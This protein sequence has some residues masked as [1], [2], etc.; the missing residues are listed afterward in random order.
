[1]MT[2][3]S[4]RPQWESDIY[5]IKRSDL[6]AGGRDGIANKQAQQL[7]NRTAFLKKSALK[8]G[9]TFRDGA[10]LETENDLIKYGDVLYAW[11][12]AFNKEVPAGSSP[13]ST[14]GIGEGAWKQ[15]IDS[16]LRRDIASRDGFGN[17]GKGN[18]ADIRTYTGAATSFLCY[19]VASAFDGGHGEFERDDDDSTT[20]DNGVTVLVDALNRRWFRRFTGNIRA[21]WSGIH[22][23]SQSSSPVDSYID[24]LLMASAVGSPDG[25]PNKIIDFGKS[26]RFHVS[27]RFYIRGGV[28]KASAIVGVPDGIKTGFGIIGRFACSGNAGFF[29]IQMI[30]PYFDIEV[31]NGGFTPLTVPG[32]DDYFFRTEAMISNPEIHIK[33]NYYPGTCWYQ[34]GSNDMSDVRAQW[35]DI[36][37]S[38]VGVQNLNEGTIRVNTCGR[39]FVLKGTT[40]G[41]GHL[42][43]IW[44]QANVRRSVMHT[45][46]DVGIVSYE[47]YIPETSEEGSGLLL[48]SCG[49]V[50]F[51]LLASGAGGKPQIQV[52]DSQTVSVANALFIAGKNVA[53]DSVA[54]QCCLEVSGSLMQIAN[55]R[56]GKVGSA[57]RAGFGSVLDIG[58]ITA[59]GL[60]DILT[61]TE[62]TSLMTYRGAN[63]GGGYETRATIKG[64][65]CHRLNRSGFGFAARA[66]IVVM[67]EILTG[68]LVVNNLQFTECGSGW[69]DESDKYLIDIRTVSRGFSFQSSF[70][71]YQDNNTNYPIRLGHVE[72]LRGWNGNIFNAAKIRYADGAES[73]GYGREVII[74]DPAWGMGSW[75]YTRWRP[76]KFK[77]IAV[78]SADTNFLITRNGVTAFNA[79]KAGNHYFEIDLHYGDYVTISGN[80]SLV[81]LTQRSWSMTTE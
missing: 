51:G 3:L 76:A 42:T 57:I 69:N 34:T 80:E 40:S 49:T 30:Q 43:S 64:G 48:Q 20:P 4:E 44:E 65:R 7:A 75:S 23:L 19:G 53:G 35:P 67:P 74:A 17:I 31:D 73:T 37:N 72:Q 28:Y 45:M 33:G 55:L 5:Q 38:M 71:R 1:M 78:L 52:F 61:L 6:V 21:E 8:S 16:N 56:L 63:T 50:S 46:A 24:R 36:T 26:R 54:G 79:N 9:Y 39:G 14:G 47:N 12:G 58:D 2:T 70:S 15:V 10:I 11:T 29:C 59:S 25:Y 68:A 13:E 32:I 62:D 81:T 66:P 22:D 27:R 41:F 18:Y 77:G 60:S